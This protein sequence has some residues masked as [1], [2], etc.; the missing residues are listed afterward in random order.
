MEALISLRKVTKSFVMDDQTVITPVQNISLVVMPA[1]FIMIVGRSGSGKTTLLNL[2]AGLSK[3][4][5]G[6]VSI[7]NVN[8]W[9]LTDKELCQLRNKKIGFVFQFPSLLPSLNALE[10]VALPAYLAPKDGREDPYIRAKR[11]LDTVGLTNRMSAY[12]RHL[13]SGEQRRVVIARALMNKPAIILADEPT[14]DLDVKTEKEIMTLLRDIN[15]S[16]VTILMVTHG[17]E[18]I[19]HATRTLEMGNG[20]LTSSA[21]KAIAS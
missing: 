7:G 6:D 15:Q 20:V 3:P 8:L 1:E 14:S 13:S 19:R 11:L 16:G 5:S 12:P 4:T 9:S 2:A 10:N 18:L 17:L 21:E